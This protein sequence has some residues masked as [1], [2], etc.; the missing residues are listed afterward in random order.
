[1]MTG[2][3]REVQ[4]FPEVHDVKMEGCSMF[5]INE[6][7]TCNHESQDNVVV[8]YGTYEDRS[9]ERE[10]PLYLNYNFVS[11]TTCILML[12]YDSAACKAM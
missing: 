3:E 5:K 6:K 11:V 7:I 4:A 2:L 9:P 8:R 10:Q 12:Q 1:M